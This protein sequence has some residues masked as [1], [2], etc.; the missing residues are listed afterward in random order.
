M[1]PTAPGRAERATAASAG[2]PHVLREYALLADGERGAV[3]GPRGDIAWLCAPRWHSPSVFGTLA[4]GRGVYSVAPEGRYVW[5]GY[6]EPNSLIWRGRW[7]TDTGVVEC[8]D[9]LAYPGDS[10]RLVLLR[11]V[12]AVRGPAA[13]D[14]V[15]R[16]RAGYDRSPLA[17]LEHARGTWT[18]RCGNLYGRWTSGPGARGHDDAVTMRLR[19]EPGQRH[20]LVLELS[21][22]VLPDDLPDPAS[23]WQ[24]TEATWADKVRSPKRCLAPRDTAH[25]LAVMHGMT[26]ASGGMVAAATTSL[27]ERSDAGRNYDYRYVW[28]RDQCFAGHAALAVDD[29]I[30]ID[31]AVG[32]LTARLLEHGPDLAPAYTVDG[33]PLP[34]ERHLDLPGYPG[35]TDVIGNHAGTQFQLD[36]FGE[37][38]LLLAAAAGRGRLDGDGWDAAERAAGAIAARWSEPDAG[39]WELDYRAWTHSRLIASAGLRAA[40]AV[41]P[42]RPGSDWLALADLILADTSGRALHPSGRWQRAADDRSLDAALLLPPLRGAVQKD[43]PR[44]A[45]TLQAYLRELTEDGYAYRFRHDER[46]LPDA[47]GSFLLCGFL[48]ALALQAQGEVVEARAWFERTRAATGPP[49]LFSEE[50]DARQHQLRGN[51]PQAFVHAL[52]AETAACLA[53]IPDRN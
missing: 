11:T 26:S 9:A 14:A 4:G 10:H 37:G 28:L 12:Q 34:A 44:T 2:S 23:T 42:G 6:Y 29:D 35:G 46:P 41:R 38:L 27:P 25:S 1:S 50:Y 21:D 52:M 31:R 45:T 30:L 36:T 40:A 16:P 20:D 39:I 43:D 3:V 15:L 51:L 5:G 7:V 32:C 33:R 49:A 53:T 19:L 8:R 22:R 24:A 47:E 17:R 18:F 48:T 13:V